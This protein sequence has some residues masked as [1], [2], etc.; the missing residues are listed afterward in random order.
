MKLSEEEVGL[1]QLEK[2]LNER[3]GNF[4]EQHICIICQMLLIMQINWI[5]HCSQQTKIEKFEKGV[6][7]YNDGNGL[8]FIKYEFCDKLSIDQN[9]G[10]GEILRVRLQNTQPLNI[11]LQ[12]LLLQSRTHQINIKAAC[13]HRKISK[14][15]SFFRLKHYYYSTSGVWDCRSNSFI[16]ILLLLLFNF[17]S[18]GLCKSNSFIRQTA[19]II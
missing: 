3:Y 15:L 4:L 13:K 9:C 10:S 11:R 17:G 18:A 1:G 16:L 7:D 12:M 14:F 5:K 2:K 6:Q 8:Q 19:N